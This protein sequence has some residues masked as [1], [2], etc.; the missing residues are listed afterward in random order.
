MF[1]IDVL[2]VGRADLLAAQVGDAVAGDAAGTRTRWPASKYSVEK[3]TCC[4][5][6]QFI[7]IVCTTMSTV[8][9][10]QV[11]DPLAPR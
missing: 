6:S 11:R 10:L 2:P 3:L 4:H 8:P 5:R 9:V 1:R 7:V